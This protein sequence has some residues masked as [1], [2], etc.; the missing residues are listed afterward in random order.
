MASTDPRTT[1]RRGRE[2]RA[3]RLIPI[4]GAAVLAL[5]TRAARAADVAELLDR[6]TARGTVRVLAR[7]D[8]PSTSKSLASK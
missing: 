3:M 7:L 6:A 5:G 8:V 4:L 1:A 2:A